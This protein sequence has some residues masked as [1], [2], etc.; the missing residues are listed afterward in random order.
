MPAALGCD[1]NCDL[2]LVEPVFFVWNEQ[3][4][5][6]TNQKAIVEVV[7]QTA[8]TT[9]VDVSLNVTKTSTHTDTQMIQ[10]WYDAN[11][12]LYPSEMEIIIGANG[13]P[14]ISWRGRTV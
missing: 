6:G 4:K 7:N 14:S 10:S 9:V 13:K 5:T 3:S 11:Q 12:R 8:I 1:V 2:I